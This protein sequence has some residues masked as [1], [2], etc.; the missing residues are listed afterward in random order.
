[1][2]HWLRRCGLVALAFSSIG[3]GFGLYSP[4]LSRAAD[5]TT[6]L[7]S[8]DQRE[9]EA[10]DALKQGH[11]DQVS[12]LL[13]QA[14][15]LANDYKVKSLADAA[16][17]FRDQEKTFSKQRDEDFQK[18]IKDVHL[19]LDNHQDSYAVD[20][21]TQAYVRAPDPDAFRKE[22][23]VD[24]LIQSAA[25]EAAKAESNAQYITELRIYS[26]LAGVDQYE[27]KWK[28][29]LK[30]ATRR[31]RLLMV[32]SP[33]QFKSMEK[34]EVATRKPA[35]LLLHPTPQPAK[36]E[37]PLANA[38]NPDFKLDWHDA[39]RGASMDLLLDTLSF[40]QRDYF[41]DV[42]MKTLMAGGIDALRMVGTTQ[43][44]EA[45]F[46]NLADSA[47]KNEFI[48]ALDHADTLAATIN[49]DNE[50]AVVHDILSQLI[51][52]NR[53]TLELPDEVFVTEF[54]DGT[55]NKLDM[56]SNMFWPYEVPELMQMTQGELI[57]VGIQ[58][59]VGLD[60]NLHVVSPLEDS[61]AL[62]AGI[63]AGDI[64]TR[65]DGKDARGI[66]INQ[67]VKNI[68][69]PENTFVVLTVR[70]PDGTIKSHTIERKKINVVSVK[71]YVHKPG[72]G[73]SYFIDDQNKI[74]YVRI[75]QFTA[76]TTGELL[77]AMDT[78]QQQGARGL[79]I[80]L[81]HN[82]GGLLTSAIEVASQFIRKGVI[83]STHPDRETE[84]RP[85]VA[86]AQPDAET[87]DIPLTVLVDQYSASASE[88]V[89]GALK[90]HGRATIVGQRTYGKGSVQNVIPLADKNA[91]LKLTTA[92]Y[93]LPSG[94]CLHRED[95]ST[96]W[97]VDPDVKIELTPEQMQ[98]AF[99][100]R[101]DM[102][103]LRDN[104][105]P[106]TQPTK[107]T[108]LLSADPQLAGALL[109]VKLKMAGVS[110]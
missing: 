95:N 105:V 16:A 106:S 30:E 85:T 34:A 33:D 7:A 4:S 83:V 77:D 55:L 76:K 109:A 92:H 29:A 38:D 5:D 110:L 57:G 65:I 52:A 20:V 108:D 86:D 93:Y 68:T 37:D 82:P 94:R 49:N 9:S 45:A 56:F 12:A 59:D 74:A 104:D 64:V 73:W 8:I 78:I 87:T 91:Y 17:A 48:V 50:D 107:P 96:V 72:G 60:G 67:A 13:N 101:T 103:V 46:P 21:L 100:A 2:S 61:P 75:T 62:K 22:K 32:Y 23:W 15:T 80:D 41:R 69:G 98:A 19:L 40:A 54:T 26:D 18:N 47:K 11:F 63:R 53:H 102:E 28:E 42:P 90:D 31:I 79:I 97:G 99:D 71:G 66:S 6:V 89:S 35:D 51:T 36:E 44:L 25:A 1:M 58:I 24:D 39:V 81:R 88:I 3:L 14:A 84:N 70:S 43:G 10:A 27:P